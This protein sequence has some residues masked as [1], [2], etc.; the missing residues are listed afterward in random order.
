MVKLKLKKNHRLFQEAKSLLVG[1]VNSPVRS[2]KY[3][4]IEPVLI[5]KGK[6]SHIC[7]YDDNRYIDYMLSWGTL[8]LGH[9]HPSVIRE[10]RAAID[11]GLSFG[12]TNARE[13]ELARIISRAIGFIDKVRFTNSGTEAVMGAVRLAR[14]YT[15]RRKVLKFKNS[16]HGHADYLL[17][18]SGSGLAT[19]GIPTSQ[20]VPAELVRNTITIPNNDAQRLEKIFAKYGRDIACVLVEPVGGNYGVTAPDREFLDCLRRVT[21]DYGSLLIFDEVIT[22]FRFH[23][24]SAA[25]ILGVRPDLIC[26]GKIIGGGLPIGAFGGGAKIMNKLAP[27]GK[28]YQAS[29]FAGNPAVMQ[30][31]ITTLNILKKLKNRYEA[32]DNLTNILIS[33]LKKSAHERKI[34]AQVGYYKNMFSV[35]FNNKNVFGKFYREL[36]GRGIYFVPSEFES[37]FLSFAHT[38]EDVQ[39]TV[40][41]IDYALGRITNAAGRD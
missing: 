12:A 32:L 15:G 14:G 27:Q 16:Y 37:N 10:L 28:V 9:A 34:E 38:H 13:I 17:S 23:Y 7:D 26:L 11:S 36:L 39:D 25:Q 40:S 22:G 1:G 33:G 3:A 20:G 21:S 19:L 8:I 5:K 31:G 29:T 2:F 18:A 41:A 4:G 35:R 6:G 24:G 30:A